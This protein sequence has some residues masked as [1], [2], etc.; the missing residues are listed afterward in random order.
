MSTG[1]EVFS[2]NVSN[3]FRDSQGA[4]IESSWQD[5]LLEG[6]GIDIRT[7]LQIDVQNTKAHENS[8]PHFRINP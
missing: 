1:E 4:T 2:L 6:A 8:I 3:N 7:L 5:L